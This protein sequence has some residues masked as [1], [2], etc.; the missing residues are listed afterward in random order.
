MV[1]VCVP[2]VNL[3]FSNAPS[4]QAYVTLPSCSLSVTVKLGINLEPTSAYNL[5]TFIC[6]TGGTLSAA[7][8]VTDI[9]FSERLP[10]A[11]VADNV[12]T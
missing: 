7:L 6:I 3:S 1:S 5:S 2:S 11:S 9:F 8:T 12:K 4:D 10:Q